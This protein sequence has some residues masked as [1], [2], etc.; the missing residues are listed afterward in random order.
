MT[1]TPCAAHSFANAFVSCAIPP[2]LAA[3]PGTLIP[4]WKERREAMKTIFPAPR[5]NMSRPISRVST[6]CAVRF[7][8]KTS[9]QSWSPW[10]AAGL[11]LIV[12]ALLTSTSIG[13]PARSASMRS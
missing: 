4:P 5:P 2:L 12:P 9:S 13:G 1:L 10:S 8:S 11:R 6:N 3:Y 7:T